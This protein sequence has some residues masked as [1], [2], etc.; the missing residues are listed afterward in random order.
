MQ[1]KQGAGLATIARCP[2]LHHLTV[3]QGN[4]RIVEARNMSMLCT[5]QHSCS[6]QAFQYIMGT[7]R[8]RSVMWRCGRVIN[9]CQA[10]LH[11]MR[12]RSFGAH[13]IA[14]EHTTTVCLTI[15]RD[16]VNSGKCRLLISVFESEWKPIFAELQNQ[17]LAYTVDMPPSI[18]R[19]TYT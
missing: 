1:G 7:L 10:P 13:T 16:T 4:D 14:R 2:S 11:F 9:S 8:P 19:S 15:S 12:N 5:A 18:S 17:A 3:L 6:R